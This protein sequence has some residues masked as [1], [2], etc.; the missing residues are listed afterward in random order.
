MS[1][2]SQLPDDDGAVAFGAFVEGLDYP[3]FVVTAAAAEDRDGCLVGF[4]TQ[5]SIDPPRLLVCLSKANRTTSLARN[6]EV[7][8]VHVLDR[9][10]HPLAEHFGGQTGDEVD[11]L[12][13]L[14]WGPGPE[15]V[16]ILAGCPRHLVGRILA[17]F[18]LGD[19]IGHL[20]AP[21]AVEA[22]HDDAGDARGG[23]EALSYQDVT[24][25]EAGHPA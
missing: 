25:I 21:L 18:D 19:H 11:K 2:E 9:H 10:E 14:D 1:A 3:V 7:L 24:D 8:A 5:T 13:G 12:A 23:G 20:L 4:S 17:R 22:D 15:G 6:A 16:P